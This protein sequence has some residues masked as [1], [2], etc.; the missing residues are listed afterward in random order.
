DH[1]D[2]DVKQDRWE[3]FMQKSQAISEAKLAS[4]VGLTLDVIVD[5]IDEAGVATCRTKA[6]APEIDGNLFIE[7][8]FDKI[9]VGDILKVHVTAASDYDLWGTISKDQK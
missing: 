6:D 9:S 1:V 8:N 3:R 4:K 7:E 5:N 2:A